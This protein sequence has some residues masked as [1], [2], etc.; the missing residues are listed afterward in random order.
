MFDYTKNVLELIEK[1]EEVNRDAILEL[2]QL[3][4]KTIVED[5]IIHCFGTG[6][7]HMPGI[8][9][10]GRAGGLGNV[11][12]MVDPDCIPTFGARRSCAIERTSGV[13]DVVYDSYKIEQGDIMIITSNSGRN[14]MIV[15]MALR[16]RKEGIKVIAITN[17]NQSKNQA[18]RHS[19]GMRLFELADVELSFE[20]EALDAIAK[21]AMERKTG[22]RGLRAIMEGAMLDLMYTIPSDD[23]IES[24]VVTK[25]VIDGTGE[26]LFTRREPRTRNRRAI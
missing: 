17:L 14:A 13:A 1:A 21:K 8:E 24:C 12:A 7:G 15:E 16:C 25:D 23:S 2:S 4:E 19:S 5:K 18:S 9:L 22:A 6:H 3:I 26:P 20:A 10:F 11:D